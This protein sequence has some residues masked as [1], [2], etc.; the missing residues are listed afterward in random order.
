MGSTHLVAQVFLNH[1]YLFL[2]RLSRSVGLEIW[3]QHSLTH[4]LAGSFPLAR[5]QTKNAV[6]S[7]SSLRLDMI[8]MI[9]TYRKSSLEFQLPKASS[10]RPS[11]SISL[12]A[13]YTRCSDGTRFSG[14]ISTTSSRMSTFLFADDSIVIFP[15]LL[16]EQQDR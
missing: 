12:I 2:H 5:L 15:Q 10:P 6:R 13:Q 16:A 9:T 7:F 14:M 1:I 4:S 8:T 11:S 3:T